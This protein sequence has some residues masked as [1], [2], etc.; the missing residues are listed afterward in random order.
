MKKNKREEGGRKG[1]GEGRGGGR[2][3]SKSKGNLK[4]FLVRLQGS[5]CRLA[6]ICGDILFVPTITGQ[7]WHFISLVL[8]SGLFCCFGL[9]F[10]L[11]LRLPSLAFWP[12]EMLEFWKS[13]HLRRRH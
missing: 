6:L 4:A 11:H 12:S 3:F 8:K 2:E 7:S 10:P 5:L 13:F 1:G 9:F